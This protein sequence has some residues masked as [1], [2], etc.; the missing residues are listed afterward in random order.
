MVDWMEKGGQ[1]A[2]APSFVGMI[3]HKVSKLFP[4]QN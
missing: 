1:L 4:S 3:Y 2:D